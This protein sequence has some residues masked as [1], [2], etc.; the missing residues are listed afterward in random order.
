MGVYNFKLFRYTDNKQ[1]LRLYDYP[2]HCDDW[3]SRFL[4][5]RKITSKEVDLSPLVNKTEEDKK[6][7]SEISSR[8]RTIQ[9]IHNIARSN[10]WEYFLTF[11]F[12]EDKVNRY[13]YD[14][15]MKHAALYLKTIKKRFPDCYYMIVPEYHSYKKD[16]VTG[17]N[18]INKAFHIHGFI[19]GVPKEL[20]IDSGKKNKGYPIYNFVA[21]DYGF[22]TATKV[23]DQQKC[24][25]YVTKYMTKDLMSVTKGKKRY[26]ASLNTLRSETYT[27]NL[28]EHDFVNVLDSVRD[29]VTYIK[30]ER[31]G[32]H[33]ILY[34]ELEDC[35]NLHEFYNMQP[36]DCPFDN[37]HD[38]NYD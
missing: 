20:F 5:E 18:E 25:N 37:E 12:N 8:N 30:R 35:A 22:T 11:T 38:F 21:F 16:P 33:T 9:N 26:I 19:S 13:S 15:C 1:Q 3:V 7:L 29:K 31:M 27:R 4:S 10:Y 2:I 24:T 14:D 28:L 32:L 34:V 36:C 23:R 17:L 6:R